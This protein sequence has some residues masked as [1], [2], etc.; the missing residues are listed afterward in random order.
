M[1]GTQLQVLLD[2]HELRHQDAAKALDVSVRSIERH[3]AA[4]RVPRVIE[5]AI[6]A[7]IAR[8]AKESK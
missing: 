5:L 8:R 2:E 4:K 1:T 7:V 6:E 3:V